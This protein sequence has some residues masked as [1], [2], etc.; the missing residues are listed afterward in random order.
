MSRLLVGSGKGSAHMDSTRPVQWLHAVLAAFGAFFVFGILLMLALPATVSYKIA[1]YAAEFGTAFTVVW[2]AYTAAPRGK[3]WFAA[4]CFLFVSAGIPFLLVGP[5]DFFYFGPCGGPADWRPLAC[6]IAGGALGLLVS[7]GRP[8]VWLDNA[9]FTH[10]HVTSQK[11]ATRALLKFCEDHRDS[12]DDCLTHI[13]ACL[14]NLEAGDIRGA[15]REFKAVP[16]GGLGRFDDWLPPVVFPHEDLDYLWGVYD[17]LCANWAF[18][19][20]RPIAPAGHSS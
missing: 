17:A 13:R 15:H 14:R 3:L 16:F 5:L 10:A 11:R 2:V 18:K 9:K 6:T 8:H 12:R 1:E 19:M 20:D 4:L 7:H